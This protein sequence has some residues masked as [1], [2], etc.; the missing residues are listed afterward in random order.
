MDA[1]A[2]LSRVRKELAPVDRRLA[3]HR[4][5]SE[6]EAG[7]VALESLQAFAG[8]QR[9]IIASDRRSFEQLAERFPDP[10]AGAFFRQMAAGETEA[11]ALLE[12]WDTLADDLQ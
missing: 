3:G 2:L 10:L 8:E 7:R 4:Y 12:R 1:A 9:L 5:L 11:L 6:L